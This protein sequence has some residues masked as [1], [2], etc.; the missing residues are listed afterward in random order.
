MRKIERIKPFLDVVCNKDFILP[1][2]FPEDIE[3][4]AFI[5]CIIESKKDIEKL[6]LEY[7]DYRFGQ[8]LI[9]HIGVPDD[10]LIWSKEEIDW[11][12]NH[13]DK[14]NIIYWGTYGETSKSDFKYISIK[15]MTTEHI[16]NCLKTQSHLSEDYEE[17][18]K[19]ELIRRGKNE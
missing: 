14:I 11:L 4:K 2:W 1:E 17:V 3:K 12:T 8:L 10:Q 7:S 18:M 9:N 13:E 6:W 15:A 5:N 19:Q 16:E